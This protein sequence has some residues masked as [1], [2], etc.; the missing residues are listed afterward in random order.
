MSRQMQQ[1]SVPPHLRQYVGNDKPAFIPPA[2]QRELTAHME[3]VMPQHLKQYAGAYVEQNIMPT[4][5]RSGIKPMTARPPAPDHRNL[6]HSGTV[7]AEQADATKYLSMFQ[8]N[9]QQTYPSPTPQPTPSLPNPS[10]EHPDYSFIMEPPKPPRRSLFGGGNGQ[11]STLMR[12]ALVAGGLLL[13]II[14]FTVIKGALG[15]GTNYQQTMLGIAQDQYALKHYAAQGVE[16]ANAGDIKNFAVTAQASLGS[17]QNDVLAYLAANKY[18]AS[19]KS[20]SLKVDKATD[21]QLTAAITASNFDAT[22]TNVMKEKLT[23]YQQDLKQAYAQ[24]TGTKGRALL[25][26]D[27]DASNLLLEQLTD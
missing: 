21:E 19:A 7:A 24:V 26:S 11:N 5:A 20:L 14:V 4:P 22:F 23:A 8:P 27:Y 18:K 17:E 9:Q 6:S 25:S 10:P 15:G 3:K 2:V 1:V 12:V 16:N 13:L